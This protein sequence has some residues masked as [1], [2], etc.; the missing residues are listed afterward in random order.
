MAY[1]EPLFKHFQRGQIP[2]GAYTD[3]F[4]GRMIQKRKEVSIR[5]RADSC[6]HGLYMPSL[7]DYCFIA[8]NLST[9]VSPKHFRTQSSRS[10][11]SSKAAE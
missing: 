6:F 3:V 11:I 7:V 5:V 10:S 4:S 9:V 1:Q 8:H 2:C